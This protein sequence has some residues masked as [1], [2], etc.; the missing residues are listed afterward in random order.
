MMTLR[1]TPAQAC[2][3]A[4][5]WRVTALPAGSRPGRGNAAPGCPLVKQRSFATPEEAA[6][7]LILAAEQYDVPALTEILGPDG[8]D[9]VVT[10]DPVQDRNQR[11]AFAAQARQQMR[12]V[13]DSADTKLAI[14]SIGPED[15]PVPIPIVE[16]GGKWRFDTEAGRQEVLNRRIGRNELDAIEVCRGLRRGPAGVRRREARRRDGEPVRAAH[17]QHPRQAGRAGVAGRG[18]HLAG[19]GGRGRSP[20]PSPRG[21]PTA[22]SPSTA[23]T[24]RC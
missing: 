24:S 2:A 13:R 17:H 21:T 7:A 15:W 11:A 10:E 20:G 8:V 3:S 4:R 19:P 18:R 14:L 22:T 23:T 16:K 5:A 12:V 9:L 1:D 6:E